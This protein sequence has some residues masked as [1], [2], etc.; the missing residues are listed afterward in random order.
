MSPAFQ[1]VVTMFRNGKSSA[2]GPYPYPPPAQ[3]SPSP[4]AAFDGQPSGFPPATPHPECN[5][6]VP[7]ALQAS[8][9]FFVERETD[10]MFLENTPPRVATAEVMLFRLL[11]GA[12]F[13]HSLM[14]NQSR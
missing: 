7:G 12:A 10:I 2:L 13:S 8:T 14:T 3:W 9:E 6:A 4:G 11:H 1:F 5:G